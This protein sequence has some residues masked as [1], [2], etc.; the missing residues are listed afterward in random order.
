M[1]VS[2]RVQIRECGE[3]QIARQ[4]GLEGDI[5]IGIAPVLTG[6]GLPVCQC[7]CGDHMPPDAREVAGEVEPQERRIDL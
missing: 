3:K 2:L 6:Q 1:A 4:P 5:D 7:R